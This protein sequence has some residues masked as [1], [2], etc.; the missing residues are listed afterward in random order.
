VEFVESMPRGH[1]AGL[2]TSPRKPAGTGAPRVTG[3]RRQEGSHLVWRIPCGDLIRRERCVTVYVDGK[4]VVLVGPPGEAA[5]LTAGQ[6]GELRAALD[7][8][9]ELAER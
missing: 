6:L 2:A 3:A 7:E 8:A 5:R 1:G 4:E 9:A